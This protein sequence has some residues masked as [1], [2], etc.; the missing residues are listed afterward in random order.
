MDNDEIVRFLPWFLEARYPGKFRELVH[1]TPE[2]GYALEVDGAC[3]LVMGGKAQTPFI[4]LRG[5]VAHAIPKN[6]ALAFHVAAQNKDLMVGRV[7]LAYG[8]EF[9]MVAFDE[10]IM[11]GDLDVERQSSAQGFVDRFETS[12]RYTRQWTET[13]LERFG[14][15]R[16][17]AD[18]LMLISF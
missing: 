18:D 3:M 15:R 8:D 5:G 1:G 7:Y 13:I 6:D 12:L 2:L 16:F 11:T 9:A 14:G 10:A 4:W 17:A